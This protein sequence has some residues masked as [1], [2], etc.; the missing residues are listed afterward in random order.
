MRLVFTTKIPQRIM[1]ETRIV[2]TI[3]RVIA[4][5]KEQL[6]RL[7]RLPLLDLR[8]NHFPQTLNQP[9]IVFFND[10]QSRLDGII[11]EQESAIFLQ[12]IHTYLKLEQVFWLFRVCNGEWV[13]P[14]LCGIDRCG[15]KYFRS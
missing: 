8:G 14:F 6:M 15:L 11:D 5:I 12:A 4:S 3:E 7:F 9:A 1:D 10:W 13:F 2:I